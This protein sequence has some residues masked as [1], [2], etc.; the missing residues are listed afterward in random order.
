MTLNFGAG[1]FSCVWP[2]ATGTTPTISR[3]PA[4]FTSRASATDRIMWQSVS[5]PAHVDDVRKESG[6][7]PLSDAYT[8][9]AETCCEANG[10]SSALGP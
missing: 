5:R 10:F 2:M 8:D 1:T 9:A 6:L 3:R 4:I 7:G